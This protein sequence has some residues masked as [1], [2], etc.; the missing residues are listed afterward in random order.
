MPQTF[1]DI[2]AA[3]I[4]LISRAVQSAFGLLELAFVN[5]LRISPLPDEVD[6][7]LFAGV[8][9]WLVWSLI[10]MIRGSK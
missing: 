8:A 10:R 4:G 9:I 7:L 6:F 2:I 3:V 1:G 5:F